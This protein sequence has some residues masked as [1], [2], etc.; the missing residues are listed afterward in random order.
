MADFLEQ[1]VHVP[2]ASVFGLL[3]STR[4]PTCDH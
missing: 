4:N 2:P 1:R 3:V